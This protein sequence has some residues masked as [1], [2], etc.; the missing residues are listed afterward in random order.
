MDGWLLGAAWMETSHC[1]PSECVEVGP[2]RGVVSWCQQKQGR[3]VCVPL[4]PWRLDS[5]TIALCLDV[6]RP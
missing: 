4:M 3:V 2:E 1:C 6:L 5:R